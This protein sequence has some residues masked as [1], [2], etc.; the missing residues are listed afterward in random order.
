[1][2]NRRSTGRMES[3]SCSGSL[4][5]VL[6]ALLMIFTA[7]FCTVW[8]FHSRVCCFPVY[9]TWQ[10]YVRTGRHITLYASLHCVKSTPCVELPKSF[11]IL[12]AARA[13]LHR[14]STCLVQFNL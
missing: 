13:L 6:K 12:R 2:S 14:I 11:S 1:M 8:S 3:S 7:S 5:V 4:S 10:P 9:H